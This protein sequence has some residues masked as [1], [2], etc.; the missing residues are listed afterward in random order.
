MRKLAALFLCLFAAVIARGGQINVSYTFEDYTSYPLNVSRV[1]LTPLAKGGEYSGAELANTPIIR[2]R[3][4][5]PTLTNGTITISNLVA[6]YAYRVEFSDSYGVNTIT[7][8]FPASL[9]GETVDGN[10]YKGVIVSQTGG[11]VFGFYYSSAV[12][13]GSATNI[14]RSVAGGGI[15]IATNTTDL[16]YTISLSASASNALVSTASTLASTAAQNATNALASSAFGNASGL[17]SGTVSDSLLPAT[18]TS[19]ITGNAA[20]ATTATMATMAVT[21]T[22]LN[23]LAQLIH[24]RRLGGGKSLGNYAE[25]GNNSTFALLSAGGTKGVLRELWIIPDV[26]GLGG[27]RT[28]ATQVDLLVYAD[29]NLT[30]RANLA[31]L[32]G[33]R[34]RYLSNGNWSVVRSSRFVDSVSQSTNAA[35]AI[36][37]TQLL[38]KFPMPFTNG[39]FARLTN[40]VAGT[41][42]GL[43]YINAFID[44][45]TPP[46]ELASWRFYGDYTTQA[47]SASGVSNHLFSVAGEGYMVGMTHAM[48]DSQASVFVG[49]VDSHGIVFTTGT[50]N[51]WK[52]SGLDDFYNNT[53]AMVMGEMLNHDYGTLNYSVLPFDYSGTA[54]VE[55]FR[56]FY[57]DTF[58]WTNGV[59]VWDD[60]GVD[61]DSLSVSF[62]YLKKL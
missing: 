51:H 12:S 18:I 43:G 50:D 9:D 21:A 19:D 4:Q 27:L 44:P 54:A 16:L 2:T 7:N 55:C 13:S 20:T 38:L 59:S 40:S 17:S 58:A 8:Y 37:E 39:I 60:S 1:V 52:P 5:Y 30:V 35:A 24:G 6:G 46:S 14:Y 61:I 47:P 45:G 29:S 53:H 28:N 10:D 26:A 42:W 48:Y 31:N 15:T 49:Y 3:A 57:D 22:N 25:T 34:H 32:L 56:W 36:E 11:I 23:P 62:F 41:N 33:T